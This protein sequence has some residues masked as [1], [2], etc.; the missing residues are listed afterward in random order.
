MNT[1]P[2]TVVASYSVSA[3]TAQNVELLA[4]PTPG[5][6]DYSD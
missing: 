5:E 2:V 3:S 6:P 4:E 1:E